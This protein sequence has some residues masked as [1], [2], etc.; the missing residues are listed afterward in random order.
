MPRV[1]DDGLRPAT[2]VAGDLKDPL[3]VLFKI[4]ARQNE[5]GGGRCESSATTPAVRARLQIAKSSR[6]ADKKRPLMF[7]VPMK[8][9]ESPVRMGIGMFMRSTTVPSWYK[10]TL[11]APSS[12]TTVR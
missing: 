5:S 12:N 11:P 3:R 9:V 8:S 7:Q 6:S 10:L 1:S 4:D 2:L